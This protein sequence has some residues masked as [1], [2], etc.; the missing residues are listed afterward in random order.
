LLLRQPGLSRFVISPTKKPWDYFFGKRETL[1]VIVHLK[2]GIRVG[3]LYGPDSFAS[4]HPV[5]EQIYIEQVWELN[6]KAEFIKPI[7]RSRGI[8]IPCADVIALEFFGE[9]GGADVDK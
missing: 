6:E 7:P 9:D 2:D 3:G 1:W 8:L 5:E 4:S